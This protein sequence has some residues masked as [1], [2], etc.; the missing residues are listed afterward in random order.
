MSVAKSVEITSA[1][2]KSF[3]DAIQMMRASILLDR[4]EKKLMAMVTAQGGMDVEE[5]GSDG[6][7]GDPDGGSDAREDTA[8]GDE[9]PGWDIRQPDTGEDADGFGGHRDALAVAGHQLQGPAMFA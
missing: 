9:G 3:E 4:S 8:D 7:D 1:S 6:G 2:K 5:D